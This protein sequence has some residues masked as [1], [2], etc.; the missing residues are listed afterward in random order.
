MPVIQMGRQ[1]LR[2]TGSNA[3]ATYYSVLANHQFPQA[4]CK[5]YKT[6]PLPV[7]LWEICIWETYQ[8]DQVLASAT[9]SFQAILQAPPLP[10]LP[11]SWSPGMWA[12]TSSELMKNRVMEVRESIVNDLQGE[13]WG[14]RIGWV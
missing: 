4:Q 7:W 8:I 1:A 13:E 6:E 5:E 9:M 11:F 10:P 12:S 14:L 2:Q 3:P